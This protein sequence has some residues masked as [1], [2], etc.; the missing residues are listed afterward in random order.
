MPQLIM[1]IL[2]CYL[3][4]QLLHQLLSLHFH[5]TDLILDEIEDLTLVI[6]HPF[7]D[8]FI[9]AI[10]DIIYFFEVGFDHLFVLLHRRFGFHG[11]FEKWEEGVSEGVFEKGAQTWGCISAPPWTELNRGDRRVLLIHIRMYGVIIKLI[12]N[13][14]LP[15]LN[16]MTVNPSSL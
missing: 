4:V 16:K 1:H 6:F 9:H 15:F 5:I 11:F 7:L 8:V 2:L 13:S 12:L 14:W 10:Y 3:F